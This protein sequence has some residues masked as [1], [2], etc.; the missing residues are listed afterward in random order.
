MKFNIRDI[1]DINY[2]ISK[3]L[4][5]KYDGIGDILKNIKDYILELGSK[6][7][8]TKYR[9][10]DKDIW[11]ANDVKIDDS[12]KIIGPCIIDEGS[13][14]RHS[15]YIRG[16][17]IV[18]KNCVI[19]NSCEL[20]NSIIFD[21]CQLP[22]FNY[23]GDSILGYKA[24]L[25][26]GSIITNLKLD[27]T[28]IKIKSDNINID[29]GLRKFGSIIGNNVDV[30]ANSVIFPG[31]IINPNVIIYPLTRVRGIIDKDS[32]VKNDNDIVRRKNV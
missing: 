27:K 1:V 25:A 31:T 29:T 6:F 9:K 19:G 17:V 16:G 28:N 15:A 12:V 32:I 21:E 20:K 5:I 22:H 13:V 14:I 7:D 30:G 10:I 26:A 8:N 3:D 23:V 4:F 18:G 2:T 24:H 11:V